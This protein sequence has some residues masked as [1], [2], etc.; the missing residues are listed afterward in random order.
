ML[1]IFSNLLEECMEV[2]MDDIMVYADTFEACLNNLSHV[3]KRCVETNLVLNLK[4]KEF[5]WAI[6]YQT[7]GLKSTK[8]RLMS[9][10]LSLNPPQYGIASFLGHAGFYR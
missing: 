9:L 6:W 5:Y 4:N 3:L 2:F 7:K 8:Q 10:L 1:S